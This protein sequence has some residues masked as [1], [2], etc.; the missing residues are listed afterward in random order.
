MT[1]EL[2]QELAHTL[3][4]ELL[5][6]QFSSSVRWVET[7]DVLLGSN[8]ERLVEI[9]PSPILT[10]M[11]QRTLKLKYE[12]YDAALSLQRQV[13]CYSKDIKEIYY[14]KDLTPEPEPLVSISVLSAAPVVDASAT[15]VAPPPAAYASSQPVEQIADEPIKAIDILHTLI[16][17]KLKKTV[18]D[19]PVSKALKDLVGGKS[20]L[21]NEILGDLQKEFGSTPE[22]P[23]ETPLNELGAVIQSTFNGALGKHSATLIGKLISGKMP[24]GFNLTA[25]KG[26]LSSKW[27]LGP[28]RTD[29]ALLLALTME[30]SSRLSSEADA[31]S[32][33]DSVA[34][35]Y[36]S[37]QGISLALPSSNA[38]GGGGGAVID[39]AAFDAFT[40]GQ[41]QLAAQQL[42]LYARYLERDLRAGDKA[43]INETVISTKLR[44]Q[45]DLWA[46]EH[47]DFYATGI[48]P[49]FSSLKARTYD[50]SWNWVRQDALS[51][52]YDIIF[53]RL[54]LVDREIV[55]RCIG[56][57]NRA[58]PTLLE[59]M[60]WV[61]DHCPQDRGENYQLAKE[62]AT[63]LID[64]CRA[65]QDSDP[66]YKDVMRPT[67]PQTKIDEKGNLTYVEAPRPAVRKLEQYVTEMAAGGKIT[68]YANKFK[69]QIDLGRIYRIIKQQHKMSKS[70]KLQ[71]KSLYGE[72]LRSMSMNQSILNQKPRRKRGLDKGKKEKIPFLHIKKKEGQ[73]WE[74]NNKLTGVYLDVLEDAARNGISFA[75]KNVLMT[76][77]GAGSIGAE[78]MQGLLAGG[79]NVVVTT[80]RYS[81]EVTE[82][83][84]ATYTRYG[85]KGS[86]LIV[87][88]F[89]QGSKQDVD[90]LVKYVYDEK[91]GLG[92][93]LDYIVPFAAI[94][95][96]GREMDMIDS[97]S[98]L[99][100]RIMLTNLL[101]LLGN[102]KIEK[103][104]RGF[105]TR[106]AQVVLP[107]SPNHGN[108]GSD[109]L[110]SESKLA[111]ET[112]FNRWY[113]E[114]WASYLTIV[115]AV[116]GWTRGTGLMSA[117]NVIAEGVETLGVRT[118]SQQEMAFNILGLMSPKI[119]DLCQIEPVHADLNGGFQ[120]IPN[121]KDVCSQLREELMETS[122]IRQSVNRETAREH[123][124]VSGAK[125]E[126]LY[127]QQIIQPRANL[128]FSFPKISRPLD[129][130]VGMIDLEKVVVVVGF[131]EVGPWGNS[132]TRWEME[133][134]GE[135]SL[136]GAIEMAWIMG[137]IKNHDG[138]LKN[139]QIYSGWVDTKTGEPVQDAEIKSRYEKHILE[140]S[141][142]RLIE[143]ELFGGYDPK[144][145]GL[146]QEVV[147]NH[148]L[149]PFETSSDAAAEFRLKHGDK[150]EIFEIKETGEWTVQ[151]KKG[152]S[153]LV[154]KAVRFDRFVAGQ[155]PT[156]WDARRYGVPED[157]I[158]QVDPVT[159]YVLVATVEALVSSGITDPYELYQYVGISEVGNTIGS[160]V[161]GMNA[162]RGMYKYR[163][164]DKSIQKDIL[165]E[166]FVNTIAAWV[167]MLLLSSAGP[168]KTPV[169][170]CA[171]AV[172]SIDIGV[173]TI[174]SGKARV[175]I[176]GGV[177]D[178]QEEGSYEFANMKA[179]SN[180]QEEF[181]QGRSPREMSRPTTTTRN[182]FVEAHG[183]GIHVLMQAK[184]AL[185]MGVPIYAVIA[186]SSTA[187]DKA[188]R[189]VPAPGQGILTTAREQSS[190]FPSPLLDINY[191]RRQ[192]DLR[193]KQIKAWT[194][195]ELMYMNSEVAAIKSSGPNFDREEFLL[196]RA[197]HVE[198][199][200]NRQTRDALNIWGNEFWVKDSRIAPLRGSL[201]VWGLTIDD[202]NVA[203]CHGTS[204]VANDKNEPQTIAK[205]LRHLGRGKG[206][207][208][209]GV[210]QKYLTA[211]PKA[212]AA[213]WMM[214]GA[215][216][217]LNSGIVPG[218]RNADNIDRALEQYPEFVFPSRSIQ[219]DG[220]KAVSIT[221]F[222]FGQV[223][224]QI[225]VINK[226]YLFAA[227]DE[228]DFKVYKTK[229]EDRYKK[230]Y[231]YYH[232]SLAENNM[233]VAKEGPPHTIEQ[234]S[235]VYLNPRARVNLNK[236]TGSYR[237]PSDFQKRSEPSA[238][239]TTEMLSALVDSSGQNVG[240]DVE[241]I[242]TFNIDNETFIKR[243]FTDIEQHYCKSAASPQSSFCGTWTVFKSLGVKSQGGGASLKDIEIIRDSNGVPVVRLHRGVAQKATAAGI[244]NVEVSISHDE[245]QSVAVAFAQ[246]RN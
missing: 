182:G 98:E 200:A 137:L 113:S 155:I 151:F 117:N 94:P 104:A 36:A 115:G 159:L 107:L 210:F 59:Y 215:I 211:H 143:A 223:G 214:N 86:S 239:K 174:Q 25:A 240:I 52:Y 228:H 63:R 116:I 141:G 199:E 5:A 142:I 27:G 133:A 220:I 216:Q 237:Y 154:P 78:V 82:F 147:I 229:M 17:Q 57:M 77:C 175:V 29:G 12:S 67:G 161:G 47:G 103:T 163:W 89:N 42:E 196:E 158:S 119:V 197:Q 129:H 167:N 41:K 90:A 206:N 218:N 201:A 31:K 53:G 135:F 152:A 69:I 184:L 105:D 176:A 2:E 30:P 35:E 92:W 226:D 164:A 10:G 37:K 3:L 191:R 234:E 207:A 144:R 179:T 213:A 232:T 125:A 171:T 85:S 64:N 148:D 224:G 186:M 132:R 100:H 189:S 96:N 128:K 203:S 68:E 45:L 50:S 180:S 88:P 91:T 170:A 193:K 122:A 11:A 130:L 23:E 28:Q 79:A 61:V 217:I 87:V 24:G 114:S 241:S 93:D 149:E 202:I 222:G 112:L 205:M 124:I 110:Y 56:I 235:E 246:K 55:A 172:E 80:S 70:S 6:Y 62:L 65:V 134:Y 138:R 243:N 245:F 76:G 153:L 19:I 150:V 66:H 1:P 60:Q 32:F 136:E 221:S 219:T 244:T 54:K 188:G 33:L 73:D 227:I 204:T 14:E 95:E 208:L 15:G 146:L 84:Q 181:S 4:I 126:K 120:F 75:G 192:L 118:F 21:Q 106:P 231:R 166:S 183:S 160:G 22:R 16:A 26:Y 230:A 46:T 209:L 43:Y 34:K 71:V 40:K 39:S 131:S 185:Q 99:A 44:Q 127:K 190:K 18:S 168:I 198:D 108:F 156:G 9:G 233:F 97:R 58:N 238:K 20:T 177:D 145:K 48:E 140:H 13:L 157:I 109:G 178:F 101:R 242:S 195:S 7:Q 121:L 123:S 83:Y 81:K 225:I 111:L 162:L 212:P 102:V 194:E 169:G 49:V 72:V 8:V 51:M 139:G 173:E 187:T 236:N 165:Q 38:S 74:F